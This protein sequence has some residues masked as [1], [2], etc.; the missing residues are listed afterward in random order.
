[1]NLIIVGESSEYN[2][3]MDLV[4]IVTI[5][6]KT[7]SKAWQVELLGSSEEDRKI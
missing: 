7:I 2:E 4:E 3:T 5:L 1:M 6:G